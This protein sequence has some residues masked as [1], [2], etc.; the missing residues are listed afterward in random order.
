MSSKV[1][2]R[3]VKPVSPAAGY[4]GGKKLLAS[5]II[6]SIE[7][8]P[9][10]TYAEAFVGMGGVFLRRRRAPKGEIINDRSGD[11]ATFFRI[12][13]RHY[14]PFMDMLKW[15]ITGRQEFER[16]KASHP[17]TLTDLERAARF[18][19]LQRT[20]FGGKVAGRTF[21]VDPMGARFNVAKLAPALDELH[22]RLA[23]VTIECLPWAEFIA[24]YDRPGTLFYLDP[25]YFGSETDY[26]AELFSR[27]EYA[28]M[29]DVLGRLKGRF[30]LSLNDVPEVRRIFGA[31]A[32]RPVRLS[33][34]V[35]RKASA[36]KARELIISGPGK[37]R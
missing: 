32:A 8:I 19:Y 13:Q 15:Q 12:L 31:F 21:G 7:R 10:E 16:L 3:Q 28:Q 26:G 20:A 37:R 4:I 25:P 17:S 9:H 34:S 27:A 22:E 5:T 35:A 36:Q 23:G 1:V 24:R 33:Y 11:V 2:Y 29:A 14:V 18:L 30:I 6:A